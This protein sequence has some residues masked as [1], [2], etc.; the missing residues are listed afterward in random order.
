MKLNDLIAYSLMAIAAAVWV[1]ILYKLV[2]LPRAVS[3]GLA[4]LLGPTSVIALL[5]L[6]TRQLEKRQDSQPPK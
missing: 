5:Y 1:L 6:I 4:V 2:G 3:I